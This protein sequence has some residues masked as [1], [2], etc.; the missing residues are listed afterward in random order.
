MILLKQFVNIVKVE[1][2]TRK[3]FC[4]SRKYFTELKNVDIIID[5]ESMNKTN[6]NEV[7][8]ELTNLFVAIFQ[9]FSL[10]AFS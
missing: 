8:Y 7:V 9:S 6:S 10:S 4:I 3:Y 2:N 5:L 1:K